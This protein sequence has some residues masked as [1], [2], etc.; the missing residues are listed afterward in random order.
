M[1]FTEQK[2]RNEVDPA[3]T[4]NLTDMVK[5]SE[6]WSSLF[7]SIK[8]KLAEYKKYE[9]KLMQNSQS[10]YEALTLRDQ[11]STDFTRIYVY[12]NMSLHQD[13]ANNEAQ[14]LVQ[15]I[16]SLEVLLSSETAFF[17]PEIMAADEKLLFEY[18][19]QHEGLNIY[20]HHFENMIRQKDHILAKE[21]EELLALA[22][23]FTGTPQSIFSMFMNAD[24]VLPEI[25][26]EEGHTVR[27]TQG[28]YLSFLKSSHVEVRKSAFEAMA[29][30]LSSNKNTLTS[31]YLSSLKKDVFLARARKFDSCCEASLNTKNINVTV[32][33]QLLNTVDNNLHLLHR[34]VKIRKK[35]LGIDDL[36]LYDLYTPMVKDMDDEIP[37]DQAKELVLRS[38]EPLGEEY[39]SIVKKG[40]SEH[41]ID[42]YENKG[43]RSGAYSWGTYDV[44]PYVLMNYQNNLNNTFT[45]AHEMGHALHSYYSNH[46]QPFVYHSYPIFLAEV[47]STVNESLLIH[48]LLSITTDIEK[49][50]YLINHYMESFRTTLY[51]QVMFAE[52]ERRSH[53][54]VEKGEPVTPAALNAIH[55]ELNKKYYGEDI[56][57]DEAIQYEWSRIPHFYTAFY[58]YQYATGFSSAVTLSKMILE[59]G[60]VAVERYIDF[61]KSGSS[62]YP[63]DTLK[64]AGVDMTTTAPIEK[65]LSVF[66]QLLDEMETY[67]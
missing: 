14:E 24:L 58:V 53:E 37:Y 56:V 64:L 15:K 48:H 55:L 32:Y 20:K 23:D 59:E 57:I 60:P 47:A 29:S 26:D 50:K 49:R 22:G 8:F 7:D 5:D 10:L 46:E 25:I 63:L 42:V 44:H 18:I 28:N 39:V 51:R 4:W 54:I 1:A 27:L 66:E 45:L 16:G 38:I 2:N 30:V 52:F 62:K 6:E 40:F 12:S 41:W 9:G 61:L 19:D 21:Q 67:C 65:A 31:I 17:E 11:I 35:M 3:Y 34:Y 33:D 43:K 36:H 13:T